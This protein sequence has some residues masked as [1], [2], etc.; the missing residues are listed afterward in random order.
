LFALRE[1]RVLGRTAR[2]ARNESV[3]VEDAAGRRYLLRAH[4]RNRAL[5]RVEFQLDVQEHLAAVGFPTAAVLT[6]PHGERVVSAGAEFWALFTF[7]DGTPCDGTNIAHVREAARGLAE[8]HRACESFE[9]EEVRDDTIPAPELWWLDG[10]RQ[11]ARLETFFVGAGVE[12]EI[13]ELRRWHEVLLDEHPA[14]LLRLLPRSWVHGDYRPDN[15]IFAGGSLVGVFDF[16]VLH[17]GARLEDLALASQAFP[18]GAAFVAAY[19]ERAPL[20]ADEQRLL[21][22]MA[23]AV[24]IRTADGYAVRRRTGENPAAALRAHVSLLRKMTA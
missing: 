6:G 10:E 1:P 15:L 16:D 2:G 3:R 12:A 9:R 11:L 17:R 24:Q 22:A 5:R 14:E 18:G 23:A 7:V 13:N 8:F 20:S 19:T 4:L 21:P